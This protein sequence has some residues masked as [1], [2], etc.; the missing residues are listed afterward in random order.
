M[1]S[2]LLSNMLQ[3]YKEQISDLSNYLSVS[4]RYIYLLGNYSETVLGER[5][6]VFHMEII[7]VSG[8]AFRTHGNASRLPVWF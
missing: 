2:L 6:I 8:A 7:L 5:K 1:L 3:V 4:C